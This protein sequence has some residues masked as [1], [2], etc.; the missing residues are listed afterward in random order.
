MN[1]NCVWDLQQ[2]F[3]QSQTT[4]QLH[5]A[6][7]SSKEEDAPHTH[8]ESIGHTQIWL[9]CFWKKWEAACKPSLAD[10]VSCLVTYPTLQALQLHAT[11]C[12]SE[13]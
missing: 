5:A 3:S 7:Q 10:Q 13:L 2:P 4:A 11:L 9:T 1:F 12:S 6:G 8:E